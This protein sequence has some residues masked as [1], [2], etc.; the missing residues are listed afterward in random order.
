VAAGKLDGLAEEALA[1][2]RRGETTET[3]VIKRRRGSGSGST[4]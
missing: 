2:F 1:E 3:W 4:N